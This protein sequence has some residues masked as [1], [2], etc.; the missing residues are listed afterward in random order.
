MYPKTVTMW[1]FVIWSPTNNSEQIF[2]ISFMSNKKMDN[3]VALIHNG[4]RLKM[5]LI[6][7]F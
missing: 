1:E 4:I 2:Y 7:Y 6:F 3:R 5:L